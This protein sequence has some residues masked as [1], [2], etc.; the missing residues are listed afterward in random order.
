VNTHSFLS[1]KIN[2]L[3]FS[4]AHPQGQPFCAFL[5]SRYCAPAGPL[6]HFKP[7]FHSEKGVFAMG[8][9]IAI[10]LVGAVVLLGGGNTIKGLGTDMTTTGQTLQQ[11]VQGRPTADETGTTYTAP[12]VPQLPAAR[13]SGGTQQT[14]PA[15]QGEDV[16]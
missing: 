2:F 13:T 9:V 11:S 1:G 12:D 3:F 14:I 16:Y 6:I 15:V 5:Y 8:I 10:A 4:R 7:K